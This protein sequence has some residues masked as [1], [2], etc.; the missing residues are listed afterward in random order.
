MSA[1]RIERRSIDVIPDAEWHGGGADISWLVGLVV[2][3]AI[4]Y[5][6]AKRI[7]NPPPR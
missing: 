4:Y 6:W 3:A 5:P 2:A 1:E 7:T